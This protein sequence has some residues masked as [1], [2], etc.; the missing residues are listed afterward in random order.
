MTCLSE[1]N[2]KEATF[3]NFSIVRSRAGLSL[4]AISYR[5]D[6]VFLSR[7]IVVKTNNN[8]ENRGGERISFSYTK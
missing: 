4:L 3:K 6:K 2:Y 7:Y 1:Q 5:D 8:C